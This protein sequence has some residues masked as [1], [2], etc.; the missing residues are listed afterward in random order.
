MAVLGEIGSH[1][2]D[3]FEFTAYFLV[4]EMNLLSIFFGF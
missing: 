4:E 2:E 3:W 1:Y